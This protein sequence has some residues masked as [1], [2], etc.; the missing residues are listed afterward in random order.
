M[1]IV[2]DTALQVW[3]S[4]AKANLEA[5]QRPFDILGPETIDADCDG[6]PGLVQ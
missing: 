1:N 5:Y 2:S 4:Y 3:I 6:R